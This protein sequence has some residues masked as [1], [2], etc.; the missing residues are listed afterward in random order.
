MP[1]STNTVFHFTNSFENIVSILEN[2]FRPHFCLEDLT[3]VMPDRIH[4]ADLVF[5][6]PMICFCD[7]PLSQATPH[8][9]RY[10]QYGIG[11]SKRW[12]IQAGLCPV[13]YIIQN[14]PLASKLFSIISKLSTLPRDKVG[15]SPEMDYFHD[16]SSYLKPYEGFSPKG[17]S[18]KIW[19]FYDEREWRFVPDLSGY[20][21]RYGIAK[22][23]YIDETKRET[24]NRFLWNNFT[25]SFALND[26]EYIIVSQKREIPD[27]NSIVAKIISKTEGQKSAPIILSSKQ[28]R[29]DF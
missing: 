6:I 21:L 10:G 28:I 29:Q 19:R 25:L 14:S 11:L 22:D 26:I 13:L 8:L 18:K 27:M 2:N 9:K 16:F 7:I 17:D 20:P 3:V 15:N 23:E 24:A 1:I 5:A 12:A 4:E